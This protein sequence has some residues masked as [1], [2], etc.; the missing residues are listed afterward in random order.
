MERREAITKAL[1]ALG[2]T[3]S[4]PTVISI[5]DSC[6]SKATDWQPQFFSRQQAAFISELSETIL[7]KTKTPGA[8]DLMLDRFIDQFI[9]T[10]FSKQEQQDFLNGIE[11][12]NKECKE[13][14]GE[15]FVD[16]S[17]EQR[18]KILV[19]MEENAAKTPLSFWGINMQKDPPPLPFY[20][21]AKG[22]VLLGYFT[23]EKVGKNLLKYDPVPGKFV[24]NM[25]LAQQDH[26]SFE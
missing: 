23:S 26:I 3:I 16:L 7:P 6:N 18:K 1:L 10:V 13:V 20:R 5:F 17:P 25:S 9:P 2:C 11:T 24:A 14:L 8:K 12:F 19:R 22:L 21:K 15:N 4:V